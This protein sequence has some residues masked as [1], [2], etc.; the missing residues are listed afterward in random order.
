[1][2]SPAPLPL[3]LS[4]E[5]AGFAGFVLAGEETRFIARHA[6]RSGRGMGIKVYPVRLLIL[7]TKAKAQANDEIGV[8]W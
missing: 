5:F 4:A 1:L 2:L 3:C 6:R 8:A 7:S